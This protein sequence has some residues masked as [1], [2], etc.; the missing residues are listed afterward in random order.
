MYVNRTLYADVPF[1]LRFRKLMTHD[2]AGNRSLMRA[3]IRNVIDYSAKLGRR[4]NTD[5][6][7]LFTVLPGTSD[8]VHSGARPRS[9]LNDHEP[10]RVKGS[11]LNLA[12]LLLEARENANVNARS[13][14][15][16]AIPEKDPSRG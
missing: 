5:D 10:P 9:L 6:V 1:A 11:P 14:T 2:L 4:G 16:R 12:L 13:R 7:D 15:I 8:H 3:Q